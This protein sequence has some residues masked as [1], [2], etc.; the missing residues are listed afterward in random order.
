MEKDE[1][2][3]FST[4]NYT[5]LA[6]LDIVTAQAL[7]KGKNGM[8]DELR[9]AAA[10]S[11]DLKSIPEYFEHHDV[12]RP[13]ELVV[14]HHLEALIN[15]IF[16]VRKNAEKTLSR[17]ELY[18]YDK[19]IIQYLDISKLLPRLKS[20]IRE[21]F[22]SMVQVKQ[23]IELCKEGSNVNKEVQGIKKPNTQDERNKKIKNEDAYYKYLTYSGTMEKNKRLNPKNDL[24]DTYSIHTFD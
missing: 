13:P 1:K 21:Y 11:E 9:G 7:K 3:S 15:E 5:A 6:E 8:S 19:N 24:D 22:D 14:D 17:N 12:R 16:D 20:T 2:P 4:S 23:V 18:A 10:V